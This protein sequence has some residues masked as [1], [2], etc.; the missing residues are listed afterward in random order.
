[1]YQKNW[2]DW[3]NKI[4]NDYDNPTE[5]NLPALFTRWN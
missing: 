5:N 1:M 2:E 4:I 3:R